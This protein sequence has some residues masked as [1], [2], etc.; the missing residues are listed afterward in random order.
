MK[1]GKY[2]KCKHCGIDFYEFPY[3]K[4]KKKF[5][6]TGCANKYNASKLSENRKGKG[7]PMYGKIAWNK[8]KNYEQPKT[9]GENHYN[10]K[11]GKKKRIKKQNSKAGF[12][13]GNKT[14]SQFKKG[15]KGLEGKDNPSWK[16]GI[17]KIKYGNEWNDK[18]RSKI[19]LR[20]N[21][22]CQLCK[23]QILKRR[24]IAE[25]KNWLVVHHID[26]NKKNNNEN[27]LITLCQSCHIIVHKTFDSEKRYMK[28][29]I[30]LMTQKRSYEKKSS[31]CM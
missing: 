23:I 17:S 21:N 29:F 18:L 1:K 22:K 31:E 5:C 4:G 9:Q 24:K 25:S 3:M 20:D 12:Q 30:K 6:S 28:R 26:E 19:R 2:K 27:N 10:W 14:K 11:G 15:Y 8:G 13:K 16:G 7:N